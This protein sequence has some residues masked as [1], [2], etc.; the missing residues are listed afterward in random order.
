[1][2]SAPHPYAARSRY[3]LVATWKTAGE[4]KV[5]CDEEPTRRKWARDGACTREKGGDSAVGR[6]ASASGWLD[7]HSGHLLAGNSVSLSPRTHGLGFFSFLWLWRF[8]ACRRGICPRTVS[9]ICFSGK[10][11]TLE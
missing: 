6:E 10:F 7:T 8:M 3:K 1:M 4:G 11:G 9:D 2:D 5:L